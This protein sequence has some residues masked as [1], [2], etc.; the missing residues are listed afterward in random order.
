MLRGV[1]VRRARALLE[2]LVH[3]SFGLLFVARCAAFRSLSVGESSTSR[4]DYCHILS[5]VG[6][7]GAWGG[8]CRLECVN[9]R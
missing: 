4:C 6:G 7:G 8:D 1:A 2:R 9:S 5:R 3:S